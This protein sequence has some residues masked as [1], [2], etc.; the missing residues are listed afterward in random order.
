[1]NEFDNSPPQSIRDNSWISA[2]ASDSTLS[3]ADARTAIAV[4]SLADEAG[5]LKGRTATLADACRIDRR[6]VLMHLRHLAAAGYLLLMSSNRPGRFHVQIAPDV[7]GDA[8]PLSTDPVE[9][10]RGLAAV[11]SVLA[12]IEDSR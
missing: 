6:R 2:V 5:T 1:M 12:S 3:H 10:R 11:A 4:A 8:S 7:G 9:R